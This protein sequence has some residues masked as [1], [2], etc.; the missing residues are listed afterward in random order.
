M[1]ARAMDPLRTTRPPTVLRVARAIESD[2]AILVVG[3]GAIGV[4]GLD[5]DSVLAPSGVSNADLRRRNE[6]LLATALASLTL[7]D[8]PIVVLMHAEN[9]GLLARAN[10]YQ[11]LSERLAS[12][13][14]DVVMWPLAIST[15]EPS[16]REFDPDRMRPVVYVVL[17]TDSAAQG[18]SGALLPGPERVQ[19]LGDALRVLMDRGESIL[20]SV[21]P[22]LIP[23]TGSPDPTVAFLEPLGVRAES[24]KP[25]VSERLTPGGRMVTT[26]LAITSVAKE[27]ES[28]VIHPIA[29]A[30]RGLPTFMAWPVRLHVSPTPVEG[31]TIAPIYTHRDPHMWGESQWIGLWQLPLESQASASPVPARDDRDALLGA[32]EAAVLGVAIERRTPERVQRV[33]VVGT[34]S[35]GQFGWFADPITQDQTV[36]DG[37][38]VAAH[39]GNFEL[40]DA[41]ISYLAGHDELIAQSPGSRATPLIMQLAP[42]RLTLIRLLLVVGLPLAVLLGGLAGGVILRGARR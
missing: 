23:T 28:G 30:L 15:T 40:F 37:R 42:E 13:G 10:L 41:S 34:H 1:L 29:Q 19:R 11:H 9:P 39:P 14:I 33:V 38:S 12:R 22:S 32:D 21:S 20:L 4:V 7:P 35:Y 36:I 8:P 3:E 18:R 27:G 31:V 16:L 24:G 5:A 17:S 25:L 26:P 6:E 2:R